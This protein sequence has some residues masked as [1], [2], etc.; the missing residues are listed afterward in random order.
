VDPSQRQKV[1]GWKRLSRVVVLE[2]VLPLIYSN[3]SCSCFV[4]FV[5]HHVRDE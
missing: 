1:Q 2:A 4:M 5:C 3:Q